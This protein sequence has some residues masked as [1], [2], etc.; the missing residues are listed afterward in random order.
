M[1]HYYY[2]GV[3]NRLY[4]IKEGSDTGPIVEQYAYDDNGNLKS[5][6]VPGDAASA[7]NLAFTWDAGD[8]LLKADATAFAYDPSGHRIRKA[9][10]ANPAD[11]QNYHLEGEHLEA[12]YNGPDGI[13][14]AQ[15]F[16]GSVI[17]EVINA[18]QRNGN[19][20]LVNSSFHHDA[21][22]SVLG[23]SG[24]S[25]TVLAAQSYTAFGKALTQTAQIGNDLRYTGRER[26]DS[27]GFYYYRARYYD[28]VI[29]RF[30]SEDPKGFGAGV[31]FYAYVN[32]NPVNLND[33]SG[34]DPLSSIISG[35]VKLGGRLGSAETRALNEKIAQE[36]LA[37]G[38]WAL[39][40][41]GGTAEQLIPGKGGGALGGAYGDV[42]LQNI[43]TGKELIINTVTTRADGI[44]P[45]AREI[46]AGIKIQNLRPDSEFQM[47][48]KIT[49]G[50]IGATA[51]GSANASSGI[52]GT[53]ITWNDVGN[54][55]ID[56]LIP[57]GVGAVGVGSDIVPNTSSI[58]W[59]SPNFWSSSSANGGFVLY[60]NKTNTNM[61]QSVYS[62]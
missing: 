58:N 31:N 24:H 32:N 57:G 56:F 49:G 38:N 52:L 16:R 7:R 61:M 53:G 34:L 40:S 22:Q 11:T 4:S 42:V 36:Y 26:D 39:K 10:N 47:V 29:G 23:Q 6:T 30:I 48:S 25:G 15:Y 17:D 41:G 54:F 18:Y 28:P 50:V 43:Q 20:P 13:V 51:A 9:P 3:G 62:K 21:L 45:V 5:I 59:N 35:I 8:H 60:P 2:S 46:A 27:T 55:A 33:P 1:T 12:T 14:K 37:T 44:T 19:G